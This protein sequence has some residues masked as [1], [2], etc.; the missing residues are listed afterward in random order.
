MPLDG[1][2]SEGKPPEAMLQRSSVAQANESM[3]FGQEVQEGSEAKNESRSVSVV[4]NITDSI[5]GIWNKL[6]E[7]INEASTRGLRLRDFIP[8]EGLP[9]RSV[10]TFNKIV[11]DT[12][13]SAFSKAR[14]AYVNL[15]Q[16]QSTHTKPNSCWL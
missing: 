7:S 4:E 10:E 1:G 2:L 9:K 6:A 11:Q 14:I 16:N 15:L 13:Y 12:G 8:S 5:R 3:E